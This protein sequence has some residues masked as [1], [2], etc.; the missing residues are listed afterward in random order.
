MMV[1]RSPAMMLSAF[2]HSQLVVPRLGFLHVFSV[3]DIAAFT[4][5]KYEVFNAKTALF[6]IVL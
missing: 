5:F 2:F 6:F 3:R 4:G 1:V